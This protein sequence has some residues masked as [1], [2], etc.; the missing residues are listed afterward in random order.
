M[1]PE[2][3]EGDPDAVGPASDQYSLGVVLYE[4]LTGQLPFR[5][6]MAN[7]LA[8]IITKG[9]TP[10][11]ELR[12]GLDPRIE[13]VCL[14]MIA[15]K[16]SERFPSMKA[17]AD[18]LAAIVKNPA[19]APIAAENPP[20]ASRPPAVP[21][22]ISADA[23]ASQIEQS[24]NRKS[25]SPSDVTSIEE[26]VRKC[27]RR[28]DYDQMIQIIERIPEDRRNTALQTLL[29]KAREKVDEI[30]LLICEM[31]EAN[32]LGDRQTAFRKAEELLRIKPEHHR[33]REIQQKSSGDGDGAPVRIGPL[34]QFT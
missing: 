33:A 2:Q 14:R 1:S 5:G 19:A 32:R 9:P 12:P 23:G 27:L 11:S 3:V 6:S 21:S 26:L 22:P 29:E 17:V 13:A 7:V 28:G 34:S 30:A 25:L 18:Q 16:A 20:T 15:K 31:D 10:P 8:Q 24:L 4:M